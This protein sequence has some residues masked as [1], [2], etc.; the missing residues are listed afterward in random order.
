MRRS[1]GWTVHECVDGVV[2]VG[3]VRGRGYGG[4]RMWLS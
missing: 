2:G 4:C 3:A 1:D